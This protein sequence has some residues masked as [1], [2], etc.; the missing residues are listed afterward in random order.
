[1]EEDG[2]WFIKVCTYGK[3]VLGHVIALRNGGIA[4]VANAPGAKE[5]AHLSA[6]SAIEVLMT[7]ASR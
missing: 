4:L 2:E 5:V 1:M 6:K 3:E 7:A